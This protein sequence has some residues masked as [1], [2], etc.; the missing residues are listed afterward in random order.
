MLVAI[1]S[2][3]KDVYS[4]NPPRP[5]HRRF[6]RIGIVLFVLAVIF[7]G[8]NYYKDLQAERK[9]SK[10]ETAKN[11]AD[12]LSTA[13]Q[14]K[15]DESQD[16]LLAS[17]KALFRLQLSVKDSIKNDVENSYNRSI[18]ASNDALAK[19]HLKI[20]DSLHTV[21]GTL[22]LNT[23]NPE[24]AIAPEDNGPPMYLSGDNLDTIKIKFLSANT[25]SYHIRVAAYFITLRNSYAVRL[26]KD[27]IF[28]GQF[29]LNEGVT[30]TIAIPEPPNVKGLPDVFVVLNG[31]F[32]KDPFEK[33]IVPYQETVRFNFRDNKFVSKVQFD[34]ELQSL[35]H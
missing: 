7:I 15:L 30:R 22:K 6:T 16:D 3:W 11:R 13:A 35:I 8:S 25:T 31:S 29:F 10:A 14:N 24:L 32:S 17:Q 33:E 12:S 4:N 5:L 20:I 27:S 21:V 18:K 9:L 26:G 19:Y 2:V 1:I 23:L 28:S 34:R